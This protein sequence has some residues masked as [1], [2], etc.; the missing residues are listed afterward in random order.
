VI[1]TP[2]PAVSSRKRR[3]QSREAPLAGAV[4]R[5][6][7]EAAP[8]GNR[9]HGDQPRTLA[10]AHRRQAG[11]RQE[12]DAA[13]VGFEHRV[14][15]RRGGALER[16]NVCGACGRTTTSGGPNRAIA[17]STA[18]ATLDSSRTSHIH[19]AAAA[20]ASVEHSV[21]TACSWREMT[22]EQRQR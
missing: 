18:R 4:R 1:V 3:Q 17:S 14:E 11:A 21:T 8:C 20:D 22:S 12:E 15:V 10:R 9:Q 16:R 5:P 7:R 2:L 13:Q 19:A 6:S